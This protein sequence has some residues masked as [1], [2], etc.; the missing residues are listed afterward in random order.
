MPPF[1][2]QAFWPLMT[3][4]PAAS[5]NLA[6]VR[7]AETSEPAFGSDEQKAAT[8]T[9]SSVPKQRGIHSPICSPEPWPKIAATRE[10]R[11]HDRHAD[12]R[13]APEQLL[14]DERQRQAG[15]VGEELGEALEAVEPDLRR[16][17]DHRPRRLLALVP[18]VSGGAHD[19]GGEAVHP[20]A[21][22]LLVL[23]EL[24]RGALASAS[25]WPAVWSSVTDMVLRYPLLND[26][27]RLAPKKSVSSAAHSAASSPPATAGRWFS[28]GSPST[29]STLPAAPAFGIGAPV[30]DPRHPG[31]H[32]RACAHGAGL[33]RH[34]QDAVQHAPDADRPGGLAQ[35]QHLGVGRRVLAQLALVVPHAHDLAVADHHGADRD[36]LV[37]Q[38]RSASRIASR[39]KYSSRAKKRP[40]TADR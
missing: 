14:V 2:A 17:L 15:R 10:R 11:A 37:P 40:P 25:A 27:Q 4:S 32:D 39:M 1:V 31:Q 9:S 22:V 5:S 6:L 29:S 26:L 30:H 20:I 18:L 12:A 23:R 8:F 35:R 38:A 3:H 33:E 36:V 16:L 34:V 28:R 13:V 24:E 7:M 19:V 21:D